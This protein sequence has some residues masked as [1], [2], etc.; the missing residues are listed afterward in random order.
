MAPKSI[1]SITVLALDLLTSPSTS[2]AADLP[3]FV[4]SDTNAFRKDRLS[5]RQMKLWNS[6][7]KIVVATDHQGRVM[8]PALYR[9]WRAVEQ[10]G[11]QV[12]VELITDP[13]RCSNIAG[14][15]VVETRVSGFVEH[16]RR[17]RIKPYPKHRDP[18]NVGSL[19]SVAY[20][21]QDV[22]GHPTEVSANAGTNCRYGSC[23]LVRLCRPCKERDVEL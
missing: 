7:G 12:F 14:E 17:D 21:P 4:A 16:A 5:T 3:Q 11:L 19:P 8:H 6:I 2:S 18:P 20:S 15:T 22:S 10:S 1:L 9:L 23:R 13:N